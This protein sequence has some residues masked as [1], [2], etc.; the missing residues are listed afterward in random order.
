MNQS[1]GLLE[2][3]SIVKG[4]EAADRMIKAAD[5]R[6]VH[7]RPICPGKYVVIIAGD[8]G[9]V[10]SA[11][12]AGKSTSGAFLVDDLLIPNLS[13]QVIRAIAAAEDVQPQSAIGAA[14]F[15][16]VAAAVS[17]ADT[18]VKAADVQL[19][20]VRLGLGIGGKSFFTLTGA[21]SAVEEA[22]R[23]GSAE[24]KENGLLLA[25]IVI[26]ATLDK[27]IWQYLL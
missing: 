26:P 23:A 17:G 1:L 5:I 20:E 24:A 27:E 25:S 18:A 10:T 19:I 2:L 13:G 14:E 15:F 12:E 21:I 7:A 3:N 9:S 16:T 6:L 11:I 8:V 22:I 4:I